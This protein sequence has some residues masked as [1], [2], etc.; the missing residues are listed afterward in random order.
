MSILF[1]SI[2]AF[3]VTE[4]SVCIYSNLLLFNLSFVNF[5]NIFL[6]VVKSNNNQVS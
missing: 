4:N 6:S 1:Y 5:S 3:C 2:E